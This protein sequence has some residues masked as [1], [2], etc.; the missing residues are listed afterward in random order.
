M[1][2]AIAAVMAMALGGGLAESD[3][4]L[5]G[6]YVEARTAEVFTGGCIMGS[7]GEVSG[8]EALM[9]WRVDE[10]SLNGV[11]LNGLTV[12]ALVAGDVN[13]GTRDLGGAPPSSLKTMLMVDARATAPQQTALVQMARTLAPAMTGNIVSTSR[14]PIVYQTDGHTVHLSAGPAS[15]D[16]V[17][18]VEHS[19][20]CGALKW[21]DP[22]ARVAGAEV[23]LTQKFEWSGQGLGAQWTQINRKSSFVGTFSLER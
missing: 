12:V 20:E 14:T 1:T 7:E 9:A 21:F 10:G 17:T 11:S 6:S 18:H 23:G 15:L 8:R 4:I 19:P 3:P 2:Y 16:V 13:L 22:L 5:T